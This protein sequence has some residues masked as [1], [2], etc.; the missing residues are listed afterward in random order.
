[1]RAPKSLRISLYQRVVASKVEHM[2][3]SLLIPVAV[4]LVFRRQGDRGFRNVLF[5]KNPVDAL[6]WTP[7]TLYFPEADASPP[8]SGRSG[9]DTAIALC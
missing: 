7:S 6:D 5:C 1:M 9:A 4:R 3:L 8:C 2:R